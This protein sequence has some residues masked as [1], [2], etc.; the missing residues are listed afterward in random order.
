MIIKITCTIIK[1]IIS[2]FYTNS[3]NIYLQLDSAGAGVPDAS[4]LDSFVFYDA[5]LTTNLD[6]GAISIIQ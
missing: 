1:T 5:I 2:N 3:S 4:T 6:T